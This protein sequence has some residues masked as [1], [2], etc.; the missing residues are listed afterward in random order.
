MITAQSDAASRAVIH[1]SWGTARNWNCIGEPC[2]QAH[3]YLE[4]CL[5]ICG[6]HRKRNVWRL[7]GRLT[8]CCVKHQSGR[9]HQR[10]LALS[11]ASHPGIGGT[12]QVFVQV[13]F[14]FDWG[15]GV[16]RPTAVKR[17]GVFINL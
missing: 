1:N 7:S 2:V 15:D 9:G 17:V 13:L 10:S 14:G 8:F 6:L 12:T 5:K 4:L 11:H 16:Q 3:E